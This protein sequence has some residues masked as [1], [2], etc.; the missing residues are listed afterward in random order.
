[1][2]NFIRFIMIGCAFLIFAKSANAQNRNDEIV[3]KGRVVDTSS[4]VRLENAVVNLL[5]AADSTFV[6]FKRSR[7]DGAFALENLSIGDYIFIVSYPKYADF[8]TAIRLDSSVDTLDLKDITMLPLPTLL[9]EVVV[10]GSKAITVKGDTIEYDPDSYVIQPNSRVEDLLK[11]LPGIQVDRNGQIVAQGKIVKRVLVDGEEFF[12]DDPTLVT[13]N[14]RGDMVAKVQ[15]Y[16][17]KTEQAAFTGV[18]DGVRETTLNVKLKEEKKNG[19]FGKVQAGAGNKDFYEG[20]GMFN[21]FTNRYK[22]AAFL[23]GANTGTVGLSNTDEGRYVPRSQVSKG[24]NSDGML[25]IDKLESTKYDGRG[26]PTAY[27]GGFHYDGNW[28]ENKEKININYKGGSLEVIGS[29]REDAFTM[30][31]DDVLNSRSEQNF[32]DKTKTHIVDAKYERTLDSTST[33]RL[34]VRGGKIETEKNS[35]FQTSVFNN[36]LQELNRNLR[37]IQS[38]GDERFLQTD[39]LWNKKLTKPG[40]TISI[41]LDQV[42]STLK[43]DGTLMSSTVYFV[44][45]KKKDELLDQVK[46]DKNDL[47]N[48]NSSIV[49]TEPLSKNFSLSANYRFNLN[50]GNS[51]YLSFDKVIGESVLKIDS[52]YSSV[53]KLKQFSN[54]LGLTLAYSSVKHILNAGISGASVNFRQTDEFKDSLYRRDFMNYSPSL[55]WTFRISDAKSLRMNYLG[56]NTLPLVTQVQPLMNNIDPLNTVVGNPE[57]RPSFKHSLSGVYTRYNMLS[58]RT[59]M[60]SLNTSIVVNDIAGAIKINERGERVYRYENMKDRMAKN[61]SS[62]VYYGGTLKSMGLALGGSANISH[63]TTNHTIN[64]DLNQVTANTVALYLNLR[65]SV[66]EKYDFSFEGGPAY[67]ENVASNQKHLSVKGWG[68]NAIG[69]GGVYL[70]GRLELSTDANYMFYPSTVLFPTDFSR[71]IWNAGLSRKFLKTNELSVRLSVNDILNKNNGLNRSTS[72]ASMIERDFT[73]IKRYFMLS[74]T[75]DFNRI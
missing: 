8:T 20:Q 57:L 31:A 49:Y 3:L 5:K 74:L 73:T 38:E 58:G 6:S 18:D 67:M 66:K 43:R 37:D 35:H 22:I 42:S 13:R 33:I 70:P 60:V 53:F 48:F 63:G 16:D 39:L 23:T 59:L 72:S 36:A 2:T 62:T 30:L 25:S 9:D 10:V 17:K 46:T 50:D 41:A 47:F 52:L 61:F 27:T 14:I 45:N 75:W 24:Y 29:G 7:K 40:R 64:D 54:L 55:S 15:L 69:S 28:R 11:Q 12:G 71:F 68:A 1:M 34:Y 19:Y 44:E 4:N 65:K 21:R 26:I 51:S 56:G 32:D